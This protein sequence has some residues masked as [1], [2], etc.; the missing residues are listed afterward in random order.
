MDAEPVLVGPALGTVFGTFQV[1]WN[2]CDPF[3]VSL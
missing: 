3:N 1:L 2:E